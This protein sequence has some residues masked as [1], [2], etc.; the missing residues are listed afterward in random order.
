MKLLA[1]LA[2]ASMAVAAP[3]VDK[4]APTPLDVKL[5]LEGNSRVKAVITNHGKNNLK[6]LKVGTFL[7]SAPVERAQVFSAEKTVPFD[8]VR[9]ALDTQHLDDGAFQRIPSGESYQVS[10][11]IAE[12]HDLSAGGKFSILSSGV[13]SFAEENST[14]LVGSV[15]FY[16]NQLD[17]EVDGPSAFSVHAAFHQKRTQLQNDCTGDKL[18]ATQAALSRCAELASAAQEAAANGPADKL[19]EYFKSSSSQTRST[20]SDVFSRIAA[21]C[22]STNGGVSRYYCSDVYGACQNGVLAYTVPGASYMA[23]CDLYFERLPAS[24][25]NCHGQDQAGTNL[26]EMTHLNEMKG[27]LDYGGYGY[28]FVQSL[29]AEQNINHADTYTLFAN[30]VSL[31]C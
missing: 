30:A 21:E 25:S 31:G 5:E 29:S 20:V 13:L 18:A 26:H 1:G 16:S 27:T 12:F 15:P 23:Y 2:L 24:T 11:D 8:G 28:N 7:D 22:G 17:A 9:I 19:E 6:L 10:F 14:E 4:R 3:L